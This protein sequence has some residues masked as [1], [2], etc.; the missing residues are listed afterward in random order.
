MNKKQKDINNLLVDYLINLSISKEDRITLISARGDIR[1]C[2]R[3]GLSVYNNPVKFLTQGSFKYKTIN[4]P[5]HPNQQMDLDDGVYIPNQAA[6][7][8]NPAEWLDYVA[9]CLEPLARNKG[10]TI[11][12]EKPSCVRAVL[13]KDKHIDI[14]FYCMSDSDIAN[15]SANTPPT[16]DSISADLKELLESMLSANTPP[17]VDLISADLEEFLKSMLSFTL[18]GIDPVNVQMAHREDGWKNSDPRKIIKW[19]AFRVKERG[20]K[21]IRICRILKGWR[22]NQWKY[23]SPLSSIMI[24]VMVEMA[25]KEAYISNNSNEQEDEALFNIVDVIIEKILRDDIPDPDNAES[26][27]GKWK[28]Y[29]KDDCILKFKGLQRALYGDGD[30]DVYI[31]KLC[32]EFGRFFP[33]DTSFIKPCKIA[34]TTVAAVTTERANS[35]RHF[36]TLR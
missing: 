8:K 5:C 33:K 34:T 23:N 3:E 28:E 11:S 24:M 18:T 36:A 14:P 21:Y 10:W 15:L 35:V 4:Y 30:N 13:E 9:G 32:D 1:S 25:M 6:K 31:G 22:D 12:T 26:L 27:N 19:V 29:E 2:L 7:N 17:T 20:Y 16:V